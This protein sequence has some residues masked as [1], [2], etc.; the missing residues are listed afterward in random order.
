[1]WGV[2]MVGLPIFGIR[3]LYTCNLYKVAIHT[4]VQTL[5]FTLLAVTRQ[6]YLDISTLALFDTFL[7]ELLDGKEFWHEFE[8]R[9]CGY[10][11]VHLLEHLF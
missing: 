1:M 6:K 10:S 2:K 3:Y 4:L 8:Y 9:L 11:F 7:T 5:D